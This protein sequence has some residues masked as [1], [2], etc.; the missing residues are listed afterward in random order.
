V[1]FIIGNRSDE[2]PTDD[3]DV[4][5]IAK[6]DTFER[7]QRNSRNVEILTFDELYER[8]YFILHNRKLTD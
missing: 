6:R 7:F 1:I 2:F 5:I 3:T 8:A 4:D